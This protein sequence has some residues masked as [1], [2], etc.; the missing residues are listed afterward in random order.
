VV[1][2]CKACGTKRAL[3]LEEDNF[4]LAW[5]NFVAVLWHKRVPLLIVHKSS[6]CLK[7]IDLIMH[8]SFNKRDFCCAKISSKCHATLIT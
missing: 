3:L 7:I 5:L 6:H 8:Q 4:L 1:H 2:R